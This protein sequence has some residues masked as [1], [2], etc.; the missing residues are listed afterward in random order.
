MDFGTGHT[1]GGAGPLRPGALARRAF[2]KG[3][4]LAGTAGIAAA[5]LQSND[6]SAHT[7]ATAKLRGANPEARDT[8]TPAP[9]PSRLSCSGVNLVDANG[10]V[11]PPMRGINVNVNETSLAQDDFCAMSDEGARFCRFEIW[12]NHAQPASPT[13]F[14]T[15]W[16]AQVESCVNMAQGA[17]LYVWFNFEGENS[18]VF[19]SWYSPYTPYPGTSDPSLRPLVNYLNVPPGGTQPAAQ[20]LVQWLASTFG[21]NPVVI[22]MGINEPTPDYDDTDD[23]ITNMVSEEA[24]ILAWARTSGA[25]DWIVG[26]ALAGSTAAPVPNA[27]GSGQTTQTFAGMSVTPTTNTPLLLP[28]TNFVLEFHDQLKCFTDPTLPRLPDGRNTTYGYEGDTT[29]STNDSTYPGYPPSDI[30]GLTRA[31]CQSEQAAHL[32]TYLAYCQA[33][34]CP[35]FISERNWNPIANENGAGDGP[36]GIAYCEDKDMLYNNSTP[37]PA[38]MSIWEYGTDQATDDFAMRPGTTPGTGGGPGG[39]IEGGAPNG[40]T[41]YANTFFN[42]IIVTPGPISVGGRRSAMPRGLGV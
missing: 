22:G 13:A 3:A 10:Y 11:L 19:P 36:D 16:Q 6:A 14:D 27:P 2:L 15:A 35:L 37:Y 33:A 23:W 29:V 38:M 34:N 1:P 39:A 20:P 24:D 41:D 26:F 25:P 40:W 9:F 28:I 4:G 31:L 12:W 8:A 18:G 17:G 21:S 32:A 42:N 5:L 30:S 7:A